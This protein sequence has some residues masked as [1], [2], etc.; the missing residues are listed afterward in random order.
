MDAPRHR[1]TASRL[2]D[3]PRGPVTTQT[4]AANPGLTAAE[5]AERVAKGQRNDLP[6]RSGRTVGDIV[7]A[8]VFT[9]INAIL[10]VLLALVLATGSWINGLF[11]LLII[12]N[13]GRRGPWT[14]WPW[15]ARRGRR[16]GATG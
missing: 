7:R 12:A 3:T 2:S 11:G 1:Q 5:V 4:P 16:S 8:N 6:P 10:A 9:R 14:A 15:W 13:C